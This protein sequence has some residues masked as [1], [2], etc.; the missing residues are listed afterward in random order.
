MG[1]AVS[2]PFFAF[3]PVVVFLLCL[4]SGF[5][6]VACSFLGGNETDRLALLAFKAEITADPFGA[7]NTWNESIH[8]CQW[9]GITCGRRHQ[10][11][12]VIDLR[13]QKLGGP[14]SPHIGNLS[15]LRELW[16]PN[17][18]LSHQI[19][20]E[21]GRLQRLQ[22][23]YLGNNSFSGEIPPNISACTNLVFLVL[24]G[25]KLV[26]K[27]SVELGSLFKLELLHIAQNELTGGIPSV[28]ANLSSLI[29][30]NV[31]GNRIGGNIPFALG[32]LTNLKNL[33]L[34]ENRLVGTIPFSIFNLS[35]VSIFN[36]VMN[37]IRGSL[38]S[39]LGNTLPNLQ[40]L[41]VGGNFLSG[42]VPVSICNATKL[43]HIGLGSNRFSGKVPPLEK[44]HD[45]HRLILSE[46]HLGIGEADDLSFLTSLTNT[47]N[48]IDLHLGVNNFGGT[49]PD[50]ISNLSTNLRELTSQG[51]KIV[52][53][54]PT[55]IGNL[56]N[57]QGLRLSTNHFTSNIPADLGKLENLQL[58][59]LSSNNLYGEIPLTFGNLTLLTV[60]SISQNR[61]HGSI[62]SSLGK[63]KMLAELRLDRNNLTGTIP[64]EVTSLSSLLHIN[65]SQ[66]NLTGSLP[67][68]IGNLRNVEE[69]DVSEN[70]L[71]G[72]IPSDLGSCVKLRLLYVEGNKFW[73]ILPSYLS[74]LR[75]IEELDLSQ[76]NFS[77]QI[78]DYLQ[79]FVFLR[80]LNLSF[81]DFEGVVPKGGIFGNATAVFVLGNKKLCGGIAD[82]QLKSCNRSKGLK[83]ERFTLT[84]KLIISV[85][86]GLLGLALV[87]CF[88]YLCWFRKTTKVSS[89]R[90][91]GNSFMKLSYQSLHKATDSFSPANL[92]GVG[93]FGS[94]YKGVID[95][96]KKVV[97]VKVL[98]LHF[99]GAAKSFIAECKAL[100]SIK[101]RNLVK[102]LT[103]CSSIDFRGNDFKAL[104]YEFMVNGSLEEWLHQNGNEDDGHN[105]LRNLSLLQRLN[106]AIDVA[107]ALDYLHHH[108]LKPIVH[109]D[110]KP[111]N[112]L[113]DEEMVG[114]VGDFGLAR[115]LPEEH[116]QSSSIGIRGSIGYAAPEYGMGNEVSTFGDVYS[117]GILILEIFTGKRPTDIT[118]NA[119]VTLHN[120]AKI[121]LPEQGASIADPTLFQQSEN[122]EVSSGINN[123]T[124]HN[125]IEGQRIEECLISILKLGIT[126]S[127]EL[128]RD[129]PAMNEVVA[130][131]HVIKN[132]LLGGIT[133]L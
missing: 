20:P 84:L 130:Q 59:S 29:L 92:I 85:G 57:L 105:E 60:L 108:C 7:L 99:R 65:I 31:G 52:G 123:T 112:V 113:L 14:I 93:S 67:V 2:W 22:V 124:N 82:M 95:Q 25:N 70:M 12:T 44:L 88:L 133:A 86:V 47:T 129:R 98:N 120:F 68:E 87:L 4:G 97:A 125:S 78:P 11:V 23:L 58:L 77:G 73:G 26:G 15:F 38:P 49:L 109:C 3:M 89:F 40:F 21:V 106:I 131:L 30:L 9:L 71:V 50:T 51:N 64:R 6:Y 1:V 101:H 116:W 32:R 104:V 55:G 24:F 27:I 91:L 36:V 72:N 119:S 53:S 13:H 28:L 126:C 19:P 66:N 62:P 42:P 18:S 39:G 110:L 37:Q 33:Q 94:V 10:R 48:L 107:S 80:K 46:N 76:N 74:N 103:A 111:S 115:F 8:F 118:F 16:L 75:G 132:A 121:A 63:C 35:S 61:L 79:D 117:Y 122:G 43:Y 128:M 100:K 114:H 17:N 5:S 83:E 34:W 41:E 54:I 69:L 81:N 56:V 127:E 102:V 96:G 90:I 45:L